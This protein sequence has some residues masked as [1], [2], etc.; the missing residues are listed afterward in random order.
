MAGELGRRWIALY[1]LAP[2]ARFHF[3]LGQSPR[4]GFTDQKALKARFKVAIT[5]IPKQMV[6]E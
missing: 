1:L 2:T 5:V 3:S 6:P 4:S